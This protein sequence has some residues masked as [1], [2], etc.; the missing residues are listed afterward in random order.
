MLG[1]QW[2]QRLERS[3]V[4]KL[5]PKQKDALLEAI[6]TLNENLVAL[7]CAVEQLTSNNNYNDR[8][9]D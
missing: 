1:W 5:S 6:E 3:L 7:A 9:I 8:C 2:S 4:P